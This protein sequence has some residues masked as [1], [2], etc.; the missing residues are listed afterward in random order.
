MDFVI[1]S[2]ICRGKRFAYAVVAPK[3]GRRYGAGDV[4]V[5]RSGK[6][7]LGVEV[8]DSCLEG[9][10]GAREKRAAVGIAGEEVRDCE[11]DA[12]GAAGNEDVW[13]GHGRWAEYAD[14][15]NGYQMRMLSRVLIVVFENGKTIAMM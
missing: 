15:L 5:L 8:G 13:I 11:T 9:G 14:A 4:A 7:I 1:R 10:F 2:V 12:S 3:C 6:R